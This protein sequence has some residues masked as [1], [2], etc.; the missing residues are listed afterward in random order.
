[1]AFEW[2]EDTFTYAN[3][4][5]RFW[6]LKVA[7]DL[8]IERCEREEIEDIASELREHVLDNIHKYDPSRG[9]KPHTFIGTVV[10]N[11]A[12]DIFRSRL[13]RR[14]REGRSNRSLNQTLKNAEGEL[15][16][17][18]DLLGDAEYREAWTGDSSTTQD[19]LDLRISLARRLAV[20]SREEHARC[21]RLLSRC[22]AD[23][24]RADRVS[25]RVNA[26][27]VRRIR[28]VLGLFE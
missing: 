15:V 6:S 2:D 7:Y 4:R 8:E 1:M 25:R 27:R 11:K 9:A 16:E 5:I 12:T 19:L 21:L 28:R 23:L 10:R 22:I 13:A 18:Q 14:Q 20:L 3:N 26:R 24:A 17:R